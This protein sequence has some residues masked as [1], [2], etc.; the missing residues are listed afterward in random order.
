MARNVTHPPASILVIASI[1]TTTPRLLIC[2]GCRGGGVRRWRWW[3]PSEQV[4]YPNPSRRGAS[5]RAGLTSRI[6]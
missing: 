2:L 6:R 4:V 3:W 1:T 5:A